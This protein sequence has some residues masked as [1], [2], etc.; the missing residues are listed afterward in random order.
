MIPFL[1]L[2]S[3]NDLYKDEITTAVM[4]A[5]R[6]GWYILGPELEAFENEYAAYCGVRH[7]IGVA[8]GLDALTLILKAYGI[9]SGHE[10][11][12]PANTY[13]ATILA[14]IANGAK[15][16]LVEPNIETYN[17][18]PSNIEERITKNTKAIMPVHLYGRCADMEKIYEIARR[19][20]LKVIEDAAQAHGVEYKERKAG[21]LGDAAGFSFYPTKNLGALGDAGCV[22]TNDEDLAE[23]LRYLRNYGSNEKYKNKYPGVNSRMD[24]VQAA[25]LRVKLKHL[26]A[27]NQRRRQIARLYHDGISN[28]RII[29]PEMPSDDSHVWHLFVIRCDKRDRLQAYL[30]D[31]GIGTMIHYPIPPH[32]QE[33]LAE[34]LDLELPITEQIHRQ[35]LSL[36]LNPAM[37]DNDIDQ[38]VRAVNTWKG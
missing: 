26:D 25:V 4:R 6:S 36:P 15:P 29:L 11:I 27:D 17:I 31:K 23:K 14:I 35:V 37:G 3:I 2:K 28:G 9:E 7:C 18:D 33:A 5:V 22:T 30:H 10:V 1:D 16:V 24:E 38:V 34:L 32:H 19:H 12:V 20:N 8:N 13:I 21:T